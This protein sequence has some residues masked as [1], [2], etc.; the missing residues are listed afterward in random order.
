MRAQSLQHVCRAEASNVE[1]AVSRS[2]IAN[3]DQKNIDQSPDA[4]ASK[5]EQLAQT[6]PPLAQIESIG[7]ETSQGDAAQKR[8]QQALAGV[9]VS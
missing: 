4:Q 1:R 9:C 7:P 5:A 2:H 6:F 8:K 3:P